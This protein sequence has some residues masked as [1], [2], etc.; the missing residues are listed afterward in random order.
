[1]HVL[2]PIQLIAFKLKHPIVGLVRSRW[3]KHQS[4]T[5]SRVDEPGLLATLIFVLSIFCLRR[6][7]SEVA[8]ACN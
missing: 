8:N 2:F 6:D 1:M 7:G 4:L 5:P 3:L